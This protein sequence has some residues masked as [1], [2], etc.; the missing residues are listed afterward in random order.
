MAL[1]YRLTLAGE[2]PVDQ[3]AGRAF[4]EPSERPTGTARRL[5]AEHKEKYGFNVTIV[6]GKDG[7]LGLETD[8]G[9]WEWEPESCVRV[10]FRLDK[11][12]DIPWVVTNMLTVVRRVLDTGAEDATFDFNGDILL[13]ARRKGE[14]T[15]HRRDRWWEHYAGADQL[16]PG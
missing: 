2:T 14:L 1:E 8:D 11:F 6:A 13:F 4:P 5:F 16:I 15:K 3:V 7:Y 10:G 12:A 9:P